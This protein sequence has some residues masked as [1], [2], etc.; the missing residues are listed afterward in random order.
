MS[1]HNCREKKTI[2]KVSGL[3]KSGNIYKSYLV[4]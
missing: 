1:D 4:S 3:G 2:L